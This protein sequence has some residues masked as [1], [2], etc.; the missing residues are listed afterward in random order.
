[1]EKKPVQTSKQAEELRKQVDAAFLAL[2]QDDNLQ[3]VLDIMVKFT[4]KTLN[5]SIAIMLQNPNATNVNTMNNWNFNGRSVEPGQKPIRTIQAV[6]D[7]TESEIVDENGNLDRKGKSK[8]TGYNVGY[9]YDI[10]QTRVKTQELA[11]KHAGIDLPAATKDLSETKKALENCLY[12]FKV[13]YRPIADITSTID[14]KETK[15]PVT[16]AIDNENKKIVIKEGMSEQETI[17]ALVQQVSKAL[18]NAIDRTNFRGIT[19]S[20]EKDIKKL[21]ADCVAYVVAK[22]MGI[23]PKPVDWSL[24]ETKSWHESAIGML[25]NN[26]DLVRKNSASIVNG[27]SKHFENLAT[28]QAEATQAPAQSIEKPRAKSKQGEM[29]A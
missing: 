16:G 21:E 14:G 29:A 15:T 26:M 3:E 27:I 2:V 19:T 11:D 10:S 23:E 12:N 20:S 7:K 28:Q 4:N 9:E 18:T 8:L 13:E 17:S 6:F 25:R 22:K 24:I 5:N 1:M